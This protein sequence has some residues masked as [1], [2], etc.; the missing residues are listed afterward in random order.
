MILQRPHDF[1]KTFSFKNKGKVSEK[2]RKRDRESILYTGKRSEFLLIEDGLIVC[3]A[4]T[5]GRRR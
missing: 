5:R 4:S 2:A 1:W 3:Y